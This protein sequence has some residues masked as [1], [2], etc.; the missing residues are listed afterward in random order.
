[1][2]LVLTL[3][4]DIGAVAEEDI[5]LMLERQMNLIGTEMVMVT[6]TALDLFNQPPYSH[7][8]MDLIK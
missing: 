8:L 4:W 6:S 1:M 3:K 5:Q 2:G 7:L